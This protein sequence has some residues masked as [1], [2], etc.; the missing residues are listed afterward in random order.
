MAVQALAEH[1]VEVSCSS[2]SFG[3]TEGPLKI[4]EIGL[5]SYL[6]GEEGLASYVQMSR[7]KGSDGPMVLTDIGCLFGGRDG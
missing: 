1:E 3:G 6:A 2:P 4:L 7:L 5:D